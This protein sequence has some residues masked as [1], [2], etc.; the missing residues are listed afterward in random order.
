MRYSAR[1]YKTFLVLVFCWGTVCR[2]QG[3]ID[4]GTQRNGMHSCPVGQFVLGV[5]VA[6]NLLIC[7]T[8]PDNFGAEIV[9]KNTQ[10]QGMHACPF[11]MAMTGLH[12]NKNLLAC[13]PLTNPPRSQF[14]DSTTQSMGMHACP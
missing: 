8:I 2:A 7:A 6:K 1:I 13:A 11:G 12:A 9:D 14:V 3:T 5:H 10:E 4:T